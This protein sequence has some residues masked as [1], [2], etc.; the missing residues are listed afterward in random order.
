MAAWQFALYLIPR[1]RLLELYRAIPGKIDWD[2]FDTV[3][4]WQGKKLSKVAESFLDSVSV[5]GTHWHKE[6]LLW[7]DIESNHVDISKDGEIFARVDVREGG[8]KFVRG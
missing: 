5:R 7:G 8:A 1:S 3:E 6:T 2:T 4:W